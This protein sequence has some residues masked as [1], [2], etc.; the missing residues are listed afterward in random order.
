MCGV[1]IHMESG[2]SVRVFQVALYFDF[3]WGCMEPE[4][5]LIQVVEHRR[6]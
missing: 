6:A 1:Q 5:S 4:G 3:C 2:V